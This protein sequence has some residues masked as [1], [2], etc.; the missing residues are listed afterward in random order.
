MSRTMVLLLVLAITICCVPSMAQQPA[1]WTITANLRD[2][3][4]SSGND[5]QIERE[6]E[7]GTFV[8]NSSSNYWVWRLATGEADFTA[9]QA[10]H[11][12]NWVEFHTNMSKQLLKAPASMNYNCFPYALGTALVWFQGAGLP[13]CILN[14]VWTE[15]DIDDYDVLAAGDVLMNY[16][17]QGELRHGS[18]VVL[19]FYFYGFPV[20]GCKGKYGYAGVYL[21]GTSLPAT[22]YNLSFGD[23]KLFAHN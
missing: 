2:S 10:D 1:E 15:K 3:A 20:Y 7:P 14:E 18:R 8:C 19:W 23:S 4:D 12:A 9:T 11:V 16:D 13:A 5:Y 6:M 21:T 22:Y 17:S